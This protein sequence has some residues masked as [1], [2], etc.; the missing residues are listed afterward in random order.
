MTRTHHNHN[1]NQDASNEVFT[2]LLGLIT[3]LRGGS[4]VLKIVLVRSK[5]TSTVAGDFL[6]AAISWHSGADSVISPPEGWNLIRSTYYE[7]I[8]VATYYK[9][10]TSSDATVTQYTFGIPATDTMSGWHATGGITRYTGVDIVTPVDVSG[11]S[12]GDVTYGNAIGAPSVHPNYTNSRVITVFG[13]YYP[14]NNISAPTGMAELYEVHYHVDPNNRYEYIWPEIAVSDVNWL[15]ATATGERLATVTW[16]G[17]NHLALAP[18]GLLRP[19][20]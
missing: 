14:V 5:P 11:A 18:D 2:L 10:A 3:T 8:R 12:W 9:I 13:T 20:L 19:S 4:L 16:D 17:S 1:S 6:L 7:G 15:P